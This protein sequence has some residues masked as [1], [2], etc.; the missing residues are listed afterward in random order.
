MK[1]PYFS[2]CIPQYNRT[3]F[4]LESLE[5]LREQ[6][7]QDFEICIS[8]DHSSD[9]R[10]Q[11]V[12]DWLNQ[13]SNSF[14]YK[15]QPTNLRYDGNLREAISLAQGR[16]VLLMGNDDT[17]SSSDALQ[18][19]YQATQAYPEGHVF[20]S[21]FMDLTSKKE[22]VRVTGA[23]RL[24]FGVE[25]ALSQ[26]R[27]FSFVSGI[28]LDREK[29]Q[30]V[31]NRQWDGSEMYQIYLVCSV[32]GMGGFLVG[33]PKTL[34]AR[35]IQ[36][37]NHSVESYLNKIPEDVLK[38][39]K[40]V[41]PIHQLGRLVLLTLY[42]YAPT[43]KHS[44]LGYRVFRQLYRFTYLFWLFEYRRSYSWS[45]AVGFAS[46]FLPRFTYPKE[47]VSS[48]RHWILLYGNY[49]TSTLIG[50][51]VPSKIFFALYPYLL[52]VAKQGFRKS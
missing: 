12:L 3:P 39:K 18:D 2:I 27:N 42:R 52:R 5:R 14:Q 46:A 4:L 9:G 45:Y 32:L 15:V 43:S 24:G 6:S 19:F 21:N 8:D 1:P 11:E 31:S 47:V 37:E 35:S 40:R 36:I 34:I 33:I 10:Q 16:Y 17:F 38:I 13:N 48:S 25:T 20:L 49:F 29:A 41:L 44:D 50:L 28:V 26:F 22:F 30:S 23:G 7:F 51:I